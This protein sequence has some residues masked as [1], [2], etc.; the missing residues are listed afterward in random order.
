[1]PPTWKAPVAIVV[2]VVAGGV[3]V[4]AEALGW[5]IGNLGYTVLGN[6][7]GGAVFYLVPSP[8]EKAQ[9]PA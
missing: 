8:G 9:P 7:I 3:V 2:G 5:P 6:F 1:M 4:A